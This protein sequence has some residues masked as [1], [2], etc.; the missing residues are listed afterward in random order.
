VAALSMQMLTTW[1]MRR[2]TRAT[3]AAPRV[4]PGRV[5][6]SAACCLETTVLPP[7]LIASIHSG[8]P[9]AP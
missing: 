7:L 1:T 8:S 4:Q 5:T 9:Q 2:H 3:A 6:A